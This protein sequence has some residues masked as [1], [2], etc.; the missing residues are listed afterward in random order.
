MRDADSPATNPTVEFWFD[1]GSNYSYISTMRIE[2]AASRSGLQVRWRPFLL[3]PIFRSFGWESSPFVLQQ[4]KGE[5]VWQD[6]VRECRKAG[7]AWRRPSVF[8]RPAVL[9]LRVALVGAEQPWIGAYCRR[10]MS[11]NFAEDRDIDSVDAV[12]SVLH[13]LGLE[14][15][16]VLAAAQ[17]DANKR[18][19]RE[20]TEAAMALKIFGAPTFLV[21][22]EM[23][24]GNDRL[25]DA[26]AE[27]RRLGSR[28]PD[29]RPRT[30]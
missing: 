4:A 30:P 8:P 25:D 14:V 9:P 28:L 16:D 13:Q 7:I 26:I 19:L 23:F 24:W 17:S 3:G 27:A 1:F 11:L 29:R 20:Q 18:K 21:G 12:A 2:A 5:Y 6:M 10:V 15:R 22:D